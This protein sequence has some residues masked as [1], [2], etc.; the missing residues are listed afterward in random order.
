M[1]ATL[2]TALW[3]G[4][5]PK[6]VVYN[7]VTRCSQTKVSTKKCFFMKEKISYTW[8]KKLFFHIKKIAPTCCSN[9]AY[10]NKKNYIQKF[11]PHTKS[12][13]YTYLKTFLHLIETTDFLHTEKILM[14]TQKRPRFSTTRKH[15]LDLPI[16]FFSNEKTV[17]HTKKSYTHPQKIILFFLKCFSLN[18][19]LFFII[20]KSSK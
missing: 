19:F 9:L 13:F 10:S 17:L 5:I 2:L 16:I 8:P 20:A 6:S 3:I 1:K 15:F 14:L 18:V 12:F 7:A 11:F 4:K